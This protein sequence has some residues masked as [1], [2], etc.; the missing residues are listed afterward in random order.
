MP[1]ASPSRATS[2]SRKRS[3]QVSAASA[4][5]RSMAAMSTFRGPGG[6]VRTTTCTRAWLE[7]EICT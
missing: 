2:T 5:R 4:I 1:A 6:S 7:P 3:V